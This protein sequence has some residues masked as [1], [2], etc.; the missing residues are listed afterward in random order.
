MISSEEE[1]FFIC[2]TT[3]LDCGIKRHIVELNRLGF[4]TKTSCSGLWTDH[5]HNK[6]GRKNGINADMNVY[7]GFYS[8]I[9]NMFTLPFLCDVRR[10]GWDIDLDIHPDDGV[11]IIIRKRFRFEEIDEFGIIDMWDALIDLFRGYGF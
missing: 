2:Q 8:E 4:V 10:I 7:V 5:L 6:N 1:R 3:D 11:S 9:T